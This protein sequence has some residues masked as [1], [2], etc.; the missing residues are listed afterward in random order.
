[1]PLPMQLIKEIE[2]VQDLLAQ[3]GSLLNLT[4][5]DLDLNEVDRTRVKFT[6]ALIN[7]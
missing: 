6:K 2:S 1:M 5:Q 4:I 7:P 3:G